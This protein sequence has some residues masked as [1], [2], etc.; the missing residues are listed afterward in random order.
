MAST[1]PTSAELMPAGLHTDQLSPDPRYVAGPADSPAGRDHGPGRSVEIPV[2]AIRPNP[3][4]PRRS[5]DPAGLEELTDSIRRQGILQPLLVVAD[6]SAEPGQYILVAGERRLRAA[7][8]A[9]LSAVPCVVRTASR[10]Q[11]LEW[12]IIENVQRQD[13]NPLDR[14]LAY[15]DYMDRFSAT[16]EQLAELIAQ[17]RST[18]SNYIRILDLCDAAQGLVAEGALSFGHAKV[19]AGLAGDPQRQAELARKAAQDG[20]SVRE[21]EDLLAETANPPAG[22]RNSTG[23]PVGSVGSAK[24]QHILD[25]ERQLS[26][27]VGTKVI[28]RPRRKK[29]TGRI[30]L[31]YFSLDDF[32]RIVE[33]LGAQLES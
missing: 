3:F 14:A 29:N 31:E 27:A 24:T 1:R 4:Q 15:R 19:L 18:I 25:I 9:G 6:R 13:L 8:G 11:I 5:F 20:L 26:R 12:A 22:P 23:L 17:P 7:K 28:I 2:T 21:L 10:E 32:D 16:Q 30:I 33:A